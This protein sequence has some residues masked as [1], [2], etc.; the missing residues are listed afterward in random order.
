MSV[1]KRTIIE[2]AIDRTLIATEDA[3]NIEQFKKVVKHVL[4]TETKILRTS[5]LGA[6]ASIC[7]WPKIIDLN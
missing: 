5:H 1:P 7:Q 4:T 2:G 3:L 6:V